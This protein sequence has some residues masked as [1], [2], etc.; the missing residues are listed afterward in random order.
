MDA[1][2]IIELESAIER[3]TGPTR[4]ALT[5]AL[6]SIECTEARDA[7]ERLART[8]GD[9]ER[10]W[11]VMA[12]AREGRGGHPDLA[13]L[14]AGESDPTTRAALEALAGDDAA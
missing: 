12:M 3:T 6:G 7:L 14:S 5:L 11:A 9:D 1:P 2:V 10:W 13:G 4:R 8:C